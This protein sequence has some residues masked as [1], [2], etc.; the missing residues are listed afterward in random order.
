MCLGPVNTGAVHALAYP[1]G[2]LYKIAHG[3]SN[4]ILLQHVLK[5]NLPEAIDRYASVAK[6]MGLDNDS[7]EYN[8]AQDGINHIKT[9]NIGGFKCNRPN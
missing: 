8:L 1:L 6:A 7:S 2:S 3:L 9:I 4:A 5:F